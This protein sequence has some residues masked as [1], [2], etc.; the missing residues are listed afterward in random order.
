MQTLAD[1]KYEN[2]FKIIEMLGK[3]EQAAIHSLSVGMAT[4]KER[5]TDKIYMYDELER[6]LIELVENK[7]APGLFQFTETGWS[8]TMIAPEAKNDS[9]PVKDVLRL[10]KVQ[11]IFWAKDIATRALLGLFPKED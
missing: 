4:A 10:D 3:A 5:M 11:D 6:I 7:D 8:V 2:Y 1:R 9:D